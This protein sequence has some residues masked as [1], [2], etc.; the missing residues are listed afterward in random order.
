MCSCHTLSRPGHVCLNPN[1][2]VRVRQETER[3]W[4]PREAL[5]AEVGRLP[6]S[7]ARLPMSWPRCFEPRPRQFIVVGAHSRASCS[8]D[9]QES[10]AVRRAGA[11]Q[12]HSQRHSHNNLKATHQAPP[13]K[14]FSRAHSGDPDL[15]PPDSGK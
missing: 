10:A 5:Q 14:G 3:G 15:Q 9:G 12:S 7:W 6:E 4:S 11:P 2:S 13:L 1:M 8:P